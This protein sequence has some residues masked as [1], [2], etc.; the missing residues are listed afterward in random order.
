MVNYPLQ[1]NATKTV[2][3]IHSPHVMLTLYAGQT[4]QRT[5]MPGAIPSSEWLMSVNKTEEMHKKTRDAKGK[6]EPCQAPH[7]LLL[8]P[9]DTDYSP[10]FPRMGLVSHERACSR[11]GQTS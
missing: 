3:E 1:R 9:V 8:S 4:W 5:V 2:L 11:H 7:R 10:A 6:M